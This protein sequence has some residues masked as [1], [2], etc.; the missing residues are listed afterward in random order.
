MIAPDTDKPFA[1]Q[2]RLTRSL[3]TPHALLIPHSP[4]APLRALCTLRTPQTP[5]PNSLTFLRVF[6]HGPRR[7]RTLNHAIATPA[8]PP[9]SSFEEEKKTGEKKKEEEDGAPGGRLG[10]QLSLTGAR[11]SGVHVALRR[12]RP[13]LWAAPGRSGTS[14]RTGTQ[15]QGCTAMRLPPLRRCRPRTSARLRPLETR[16]AF[17]VV[18]MRQPGEQTSQRVAKS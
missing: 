8:E 12:T 16:Y 15:A 18:D 11:L 3:R 4:R 2:I 9:T 13:T 1:A 6:R 10:D 7:C 14:A 17:F 5:Q